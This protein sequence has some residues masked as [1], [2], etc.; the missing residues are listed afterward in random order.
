[1]RSRTRVAASVAVL[2][3]L[4]AF[5]SA[6]AA[7]PA[8]LRHPFTGARLHALTAQRAFWAKAPQAARTADPVGPFVLSGTVLD[9]D[10]TPVPGAD[11]RWGWFDP[12]EDVWFGDGVVYHDGGMT[13]AAEDGTFSF[14]SV[15]SVP[16]SDY[17]GAFGMDD[18]GWFSLDTWN[19][20][21]SSAV[22][23]VIRPGHVRVNVV[24]APS[25]GGLTVTTGDV[26]S[27]SASSSAVLKGGLVV[28]K[29][30]SPGIVTA[31]VQSDNDAGTVS[32]AAGWVSPGHVP[33]TVTAGQEAATEL[34]LDWDDAVHGRLAGSAPRHS[35]P[36]GSQVTFVIDNWP[37]GM[38]VSFDGFSFAD[39]STHVFDQV[40]TS[41]GPES[42]YRVRL[43]IPEDARTGD[44]YDIDAYRSDDPAAL[45]YVYDYFLVCDFGA[46]RSVI[47]RG[48]AVRLHGRIDGYHV[49]LFKRTAVAPQPAK[50]SAPGWTKV[51]SFETTSRGRFRTGFMKPRRTTWYVA[52]YR[53]GDF[54]AF[55]QVVKVTVRND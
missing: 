27:G 53:G 36:P 34:A 51:R 16:G 26:T 48:Q 11:V 45:L 10:G 12:N 37:D 17:L 23:R 18:G 33:V 52:R 1:M 22:P 5:A 40:V 8:M 29:A 38:Q 50:L 2:L 42:T 14:P 21:F 20:D 9:Y 25:G 41:Q 35:G 13:S 15:S 32:A 19:A 6:A 7:A 46:S 47:D 49:T 44:V 39:G 55:T 24:H 28:A 54:E 30:L 4:L 3:A 43:A 31:Q